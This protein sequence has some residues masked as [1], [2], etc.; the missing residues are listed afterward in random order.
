[1]HRILID[2]HNDLPWAHREEFGLDLDLAGLAEHQPR[3]RTDL[4]RLSG[5]GVNGQFWSVFVPPAMAE[6]EA[7]VAT[8]EQIDFVRRMV[9]RYDEL[10][11]VTTADQVVAAVADGK[12]ASLLGVEGGHS[13]GSS[14]GVLRQLHALGVRY[15]TL[16]HNDN[17]PWADSATDAPG[18]GG[19]SD[20]GRAIVAEMNR[21]GMMVDLSH[22]ADSTMRHA[23]DASSA[24]VIFSHSNARGVCD[25]PRNVP[26]DILARLPGN[27]GLVM[28]TF[29][30]SFV[31]PSVATWMNEAVE[32][33]QLTHPDPDFRPDPFR[34]MRDR[35]LSD[36]PPHAGIDDV[37]RHFD[38]LRDAI[39]VAHIGIGGDFDGSDQ[40]ITGLEDVSCYP[41]L[42]EALR[43]RRWSPAELEA[44][45]G[46][47]VLRV[48]RD[49]E[50]V[51]YCDLPR[52]VI[53]HTTSTRSLRIA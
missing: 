27:G 20:T 34:A 43:E 39:G 3:L 42:F 12:L 40:V 32:L 24:P 7:V 49:V 4:P 19:L 26:D 28:V 47:N 30:P 29:V 37:V 1:M 38:Y 8:L 52:A 21:I 51:A 53:G 35:S 17:V 48:M 44:V 22:V 16:T 6:P 50:S 14:L 18:V 46:A 13:I 5:G 41:R 15:M 23:L 25:V 9:D 33:A 36:P 45:A 2:G 10:E 11:L 31:S